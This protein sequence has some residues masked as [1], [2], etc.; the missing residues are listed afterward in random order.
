MKQE[1]FSRQQ[2]G[3][4]PRALAGGEVNVVTQNTSDF[5]P[6]EEIHLENWFEG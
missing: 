1:V 6:F 5:E 2:S 3:R 4:I